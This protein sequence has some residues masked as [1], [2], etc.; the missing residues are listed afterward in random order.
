MTPSIQCV[1]A[2]CGGVGYDAG[3]IFW[4]HYAERS[5]VWKVSGVTA[6]IAAFEVAG[7]LQA[8]HGVGPAV[9]LVIGCGFGAGIATWVKKRFVRE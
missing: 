2:F 3:Y 6:L 7:I 9:C 8:V 1:V 4:A 5:R